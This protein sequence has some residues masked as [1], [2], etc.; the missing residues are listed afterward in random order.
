METPLIISPAS[1]GD[2]EPKALA[3]SEESDGRIMGTVI[4]HFAWNFSLA[5]NTGIFT[6]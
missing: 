2:T 1:E 4:G 5:M 6:Y 3:I